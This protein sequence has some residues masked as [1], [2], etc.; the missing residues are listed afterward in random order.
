MRV[1]TNILE[2]HT[3]IFIGKWYLKFTLNPV[4]WENIKFSKI[5]ECSSG[6]SLA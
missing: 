3:K 1:D 6:S 2:I 4:G 5:E